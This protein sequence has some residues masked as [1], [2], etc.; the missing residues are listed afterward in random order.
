MAESPSENQEITAP[1][2]PDIAIRTMASDTAA[3]KAGGGQILGTIVSADTDSKTR[4]G[5][6]ESVFKSQD[7]IRSTSDLSRSN[8]LKSLV[9]IIAIMV[10]AGVAALFGYSVLFPWLFKK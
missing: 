6:G 3:I 7:A 5:S 9:I 4:F 1:P 2:A 10:I 8:T